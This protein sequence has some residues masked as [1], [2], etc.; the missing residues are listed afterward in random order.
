MTD[1]HETA[2]LRDVELGERTTVWAYSNLYECFVGT[3]CLI[4]PYVEIQSGVKIGDEV[5]VQS[6]SFLCQEMIIEDR[7]WIGHGVQTVN[8]LYPPGEPP[9]DPPVVCE[10]AVVGT[11]A[12]LMPVEIGENAVVGAGAVVVNDVP[13]DTTVVGNPARPADDV[14]GRTW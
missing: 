5:A 4:G 7:A 3:D 10:G 8:N 9:W 14:N 6:H 13:P 11:G 2:L 12:I 1:V